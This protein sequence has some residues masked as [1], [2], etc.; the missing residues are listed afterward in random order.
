MNK[1]LKEIKIRKK[2]AV[3]IILIFLTSTLIMGRQ[4]MSFNYFYVSTDDTFAYTS[5]AIQFIDA[6]K[7]GIIY[8]RWIPLNFWKYGSPTFIFY[9]PLSYYLVALFSTFADSVIS[10]M[11]L[12][13]FISLFLSAVGIYFLVKEFYSAKI[14][15]LSSILYVIFP[16]TVFNLYIL[17]GF[18]S[19]V[20]LMWFPLIILFIYKYFKSNQFK[21]LVFAGLCYG[22]LILTH[23]INAYMFLFILAS[24]VIYMAI[25]KKRPKNLVALFFILL[26]GILASAVYTFPFIYEKPFINFE[27]FKV[28]NYSDFFILPNKA[29][30]FPSI[31]VWP[32]YYFTHLLYILISTIFLYLFYIQTLKLRNIAAMQESF[33]INKFFVYIFLFTIFL[34]FGISS[35]IWEIIP[36]FKYIQFPGRWTNITVFSVVFL[37]AVGFYEMLLQKRKTKY[38]IALLLLLLLLLLDVIVIKKA[39]IFKKEELL[40]PKSVN[41]TI[42]HLPVGVDINKIKNDSL[43][44]AVIISG[45]GSLE[46]EEWGSA[47]RIIRVS[48]NEPMTLR[49]RTFY[50]PGWKAYIDNKDIKIEKEKDTCAMLINVPK[51]KYIL[52][53]EFQDTPIRFY[54]KILTFI[55]FVIIALYLILQAFMKKL[56]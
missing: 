12:V 25:I 14:A 20:S 6:L 4:I 11:N 9:P 34:Q 18:T 7:E 36:Y 45:T 22:G 46:I 3:Y 55:S 49:I 54:S 8:P 24:F 13:K 48:A 53:L 51:G 28:F 50:F 15:L 29:K 38:Y 26:I 39:Y 21:N 17:G 23:L 35:F 40:P 16:S 33:V 44:K 32:T 52:R 5:W 41:W 42:E 43:E 10:A 37:S 30:D 27:A 31:H 2:T 19:T 56:K 1:L 47:K